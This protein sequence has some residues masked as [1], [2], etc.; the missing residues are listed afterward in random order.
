[1][2]N[3]RKGQCEICGETNRA[4]LD[5]HH[6]IPRTDE[7]STDLMSNLAY[8][9]SNHHREVH[10]GIYVIEGWYMTT[11]G[12]KL[13]WHRENEPYNIRP[14]IIFRDGQVIIKEIDD[15]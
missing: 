1:M 11:G 9:C 15:E 12:R 6:I 13:Y 7:R 10:A 2:K 8:L 3:K 4:V 14:G 5:L